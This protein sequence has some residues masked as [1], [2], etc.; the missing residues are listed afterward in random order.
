MPT[1]PDL[2]SARC[3]ARIVHQMIGDRQ[4][5]TGLHGGAIVGMIAGDPPHPMPAKLRQDSRRRSTVV[6]I[7]AGQTK[8]GIGLV[9]GD[10][11]A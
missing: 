2:A 3:A 7:W 11:G 5:S 9:P 1:E 4:E 6:P 10:S 8:D